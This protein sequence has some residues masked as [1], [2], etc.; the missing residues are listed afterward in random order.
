MGLGNQSKS[1]HSSGG[2]KK[3]IVVKQIKA[4]GI[5]QAG[6]PFE[7]DVSV[8]LEGMGWALGRGKKEKYRIPLGFGPSSGRGQTEA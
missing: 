1:K 6:L 3:K 4:L 2:K 7:L 5:S 8:I